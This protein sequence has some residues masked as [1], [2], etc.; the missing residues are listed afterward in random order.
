MPQSQERHSIWLILFELSELGFGWKNIDFCKIPPNV[1]A[2]VPLIFILIISNDDPSDWTSQDRR[3]LM[4]VVIGDASLHE[5]KAT[6]MPHC[7]FTGN[8]MSVSE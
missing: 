8:N 7:N 3:K 6:H 2:R 1:N 5:R 4:L